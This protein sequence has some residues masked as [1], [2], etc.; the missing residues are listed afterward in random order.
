MKKLIV[1]ILWFLINKLDPLSIEST[2]ITT[3]GITIKFKK[4]FLRKDTWHMLTTT[5][6]LWVKKGDTKSEIAEV[7]IWKDTKLSEKYIM[8]LIK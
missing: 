7:C 6:N 2:N 3:E 4:R 1:N 8:N 5:I